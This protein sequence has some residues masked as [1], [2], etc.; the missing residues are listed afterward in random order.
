MNALIAEGRRLIAAST[1]GPVGIWGEDD[2]PD[3]DDLCI[4]AFDVSA[5]GADEDGPSLFLCNV[6]SN[7]GAH[8]PLA[9]VEAET[10][11][12]ISL[13]N[14]QRLALGWNALPAL[15]D[16]A[17]AAE[18]LLAY[19]DNCGMESTPCDALRAALAKLKEVK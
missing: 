17:E 5:P 19:H 1:P 16:A 2:L 15:L 8:G 7:G 10:K 14:A 3:H 6:G 11:W 12:P 4:A 9:P 13:A 18:R